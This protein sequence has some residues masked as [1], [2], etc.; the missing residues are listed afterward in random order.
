MYDRLVLNLE[1]S[2]KKQIATILLA[3]A[4]ALKKALLSLQ[5]KK[6]EDVESEDNEE[7]LEN[8]SN[9][10]TDK[11]FILITALLGTEYYNK[12][13]MPI[14]L[15]AG[16]TGIDFFNSLHYSNEND[17][18]KYEDVEAD[19]TSWLKNYSKQEI[20]YINNTTRNQVQRI[21]KNGLS[22]GDNY[23]KIADDLFKHVK[24]ISSSRTR[25]V[26]ETE[27]HNVVGKINFLSATYKDMQDKTWNSMEDARVRPAHAELDGETIPIGEEFLPGLSYPG[28]SN[29]SS[30]LV[31]NCRCW[32]SYD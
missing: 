25:T 20:E 9:G 19:Y 14:Y 26:A 10:I 12:L 28:D 11:I 13:I 1:K 8:Q 2:F 24:N 29:A 6:D 15:Q 30:D 27:I 5:Q 31:V 21:V 32:L 7:E 22:N 18:I 23:D 3:Q 4:K 17:Y 16:K